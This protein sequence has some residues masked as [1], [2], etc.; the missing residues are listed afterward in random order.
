MKKILILGGAGTMGSE[1][2]KLLLER[3]D[4]QLTVADY[5]AKG[6]KRVQAELGN[7]VQ[8]AVIDVNDKE[9]LVKLLKSADIAISTVGPFYKFATTI[10]KAAIEA[11]VN[12]VDIDDDYDATRDSLDLDEAAKKAGITAIIGMGASPGMTN[13]VAKLGADRMDSTDTIRFYWGESALDPTGPAAMVHW[14]HIT[15]EKV[16]AFINGKWVDVRGFSEPEEVEFMA[17]L[18]KQTVIYTGHP[19]PVSLPRYIKGLKNCSIKGAL[20]PA[21]MMELYGQL[22]ETGFGS[23]DEFIINENTS[24]PFRELAVKIIRNMPRLAPAY[25]TEILHEALEKY[26]DCAGA[27][28]IVVSGKKGKQAQTI[29]YDLMASNVAYSTALPA[30]IAALTVLDG[31]AKQAGVMAPEG[32]LDARLF[33]DILSKDAKV[34]ETVTVVNDQIAFK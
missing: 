12:I 1:A 18:G 10:L 25:F 29:T 6:L 7:K 8:T 20:Y 17:P 23:R 5:S 34:Q 22:I 21:K 9:A 15:S 19:E 33:V 13:L 30:V 2:T 32:A 26:Q 28:K 24:M 16:P 11:H 3:S 27:F 31:K 14:F 4:A